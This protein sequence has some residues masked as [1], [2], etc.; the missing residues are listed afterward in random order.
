MREKAIADP[1]VE[2][3]LNRM[4]YFKIPCTAHQ[5]LFLSQSLQKLREVSKNFPSEAK[6]SG[7]S[8]LKAL[9]NRTAPLAVNLMSAIYCVPSQVVK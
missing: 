3:A 9:R 2:T 5:I 1:L 6:C 7:S 8:A 4:G